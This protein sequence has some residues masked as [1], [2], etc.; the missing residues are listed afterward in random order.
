DYLDYELFFGLPRRPPVPLES[1]LAS[2]EAADANGDGRI[3]G[4]DYLIAFGL[5]PRP[6]ALSFDEWLASPE[7]ADLNGD[8]EVDLLDYEHWLR[9]PAPMDLD[10][11]LQSPEAADLSGDG[12]IDVLDYKAFQWLGG[13]EAEDLDGDGLI[14]FADFEA[15]LLDSGGAGTAAG[16]GSVAIDLDPDEGDQQR[17]RAANARPGRQYL[18]Q[19][20]VVGAPAANGW[21]VT[22]EYDPLQLAYVP[23]S[24]RLGGFLAGGVPLV[25]DRAGRL[26]VGTAVLAGEASNSGDATLGSV[27]L[28]VLDGFAGTTEVVIARR[29]LRLVG[30]EQVFDAQS[31]AVTITDELL[32]EPLAAD[33]D[34]DGVVDLADF[35]AFAGAFWSS[36]PVYDLSGDGFVDFTDL[37]AFAEQFGEEMPAYKL[38]ALAQEYLGLPAAA[39]L[40]PGYPN[41]FNASTTIP[42][43]VPAPAPVR[44]EVYD[45]LGQ[46]VR[47]LVSGAVEPGRHQVVWDGLDDGGSPVGTGVYYCR[48]TADLPAMPGMGAGGGRAGGFSAVRKLLLAR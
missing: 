25:S 32:G 44:L 26:G 34:G 35:Y 24:F 9:G 39:S 23:Q 22:I 17:R 6:P 18:L 40:E 38:L 31:A 47:T 21:S 48:L 16:E 46:R 42:F 12:H 19:L 1:W 3:D 10:S 11:W 37:F 13:P 8:G 30:G 28:E 14:D 20:N 7:A 33:F 45:G 2:A 5:R 36:D 15:Y 43:A 27:R 41:P 29:G 4:E